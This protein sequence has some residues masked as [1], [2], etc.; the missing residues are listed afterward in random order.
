[1]T[2]IEPFNHVIRY[3]ILTRISSK[4]KSYFY[5]FV[6]CEYTS[7]TKREGNTNAK[8]I[9]NEIVWLIEAL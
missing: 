4:F 2:R 8:P 6:W 7:V 9:D 3:N 5:A 1:M